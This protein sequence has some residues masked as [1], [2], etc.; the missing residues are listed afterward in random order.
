M[1]KIK[2]E[3]NQAFAGYTDN[4]RQ[5]LYDI[6][7]LKSTGSITDSGNDTESSGPDY[8][9]RGRNNLYRVD[10][11]GRPLIVKDFKLPNFI[12]RFVYTTLRKSKAR[13]S[14][15]NA[16]RMEKLGFKTPRPVAYCEVK[17]NGRLTLSFYLSEELKGATEMRRWEDN[18]DCPT[19]LPAFAAELYRLH[20]A[21]VWHKD[22]SPGNI[23]YI[24]NSDDTYSFYYVDLNRMKFNVKSRRKLMRMFR[25]INLERG[26]TRRL[27]TLYAQAAGIDP[28]K[29]ADLAEKELEGYFAVQRRK[30]LLK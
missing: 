14:Y 12:N 4:I 25:S 22:F 27:A 17:R 18:P 24:K 26:E 11:K 29:M 8:I 16:M 20:R 1:E 28:V 13:R 7:L 10:V 9:Y 19:L 5:T 30:Q 6:I 21:G 15:E 2:I 3:I 23:L